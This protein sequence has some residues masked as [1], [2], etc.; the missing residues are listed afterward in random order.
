MA[1][2]TL[3]SAPAAPAPRDLPMTFMQAAS[4]ALARAMDHRRRGED[5]MAAQEAKSALDDLRFASNDLSRENRDRRRR[6]V[7][8]RKRARRNGHA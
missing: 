1:D 2:A 6:E 4:E 8:A 3:D 7:E 5:V